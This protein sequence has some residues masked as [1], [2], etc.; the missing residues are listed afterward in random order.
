MVRLTTTFSLNSV[1]LAEEGAITAEQQLR[2]GIRG[3]PLVH[4]T[5]TLCAENIARRWV[6]EVR[7]S[8]QGASDH[9]DSPAVSELRLLQPPWTSAN[10]S[11][12]RRLLRPAVH[13]FPACW[14]V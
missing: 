13:M 10:T 14:L 2:M 1:L 12:P 9:L 7:R 5:C 11:F 4:D 8:T 3:L 6:H